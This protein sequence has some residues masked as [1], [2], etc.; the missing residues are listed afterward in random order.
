MSEFVGRRLPVYLV[1]D[2]SGSMTGEPIEAVRQGVKALLAD[3]RGDP[4]ALET[5]YLSVITFSN[6]AQ[7]VCPLTE[8][9][10]FTEPQL[11]ASGSTALGEALKLLGQCV[12]REVRRSTPTQKGDWKPLIF[13]MTDGQP[14]DSWEAAADEIK[15]KRVGNIIACAA[16]PHA[17]ASVLKRATEI[18]VELNNLQP[19]QLKAFFKWVSSSIRT[20][21]QNIA[22][23]V[24]DG[25]PVNLPPPPPNSGIVIV[26]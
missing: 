24:A 25:T 10:T 1:L 15:Q 8:L 9:T 7:Q 26:P 20:T 22:Q 3:L 19:D 13:L 6:G 23:P 5:A 17:Q 16:G 14:T 12:D 2:V 18:V 11:V 21:S 4:Q